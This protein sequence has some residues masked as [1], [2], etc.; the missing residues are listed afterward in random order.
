[1]QPWQFIHQKLST[2]IGVLLLWV[3]ESE[4]SS[5]GRRTFKMAVAAD[6][7]FEGTIGGGI[8]EHKLVEKAKAMLKEDNNIT[9]LV[10]QY[11]D[12]EHAKDQSG[13][14]C[15]GSQLIA[16]VPLNHTHSHIVSEIL[17]SYRDHLDNSIE[18]HPHQLSIIAND[19]EGLQY[20]SEQ[21]WSYKEKIDQRPVIHIIG[22]GHVALA[23][24]EVMHFIGFYVQ[25]YDNR[26]DLHTM[27]LNTSAHEKHV[28]DYANLSNFIQGNSNEYLVIMT[29]GYRDDK[30]VFEQLA[31]KTFFYKGMMG[32]E[33]KL[34]KLR[35]EMLAEGL[36]PQLWNDWHMPIGINIYSKTTQEIA[37][38]IA[39]E[40][41]REKNKIL[42]T[43]RSV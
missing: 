37:I 13:M 14:I 33:T 43:G 24:S 9:S 12:K 32:S 28:V 41:I 8:M 2:S 40:I 27:Q 6:G 5:P 23:L 3:L 4:G 25:V 38:S 17:L 19:S 1:M 34:A 42:P 30:L 35:N 29:F 26:N 20:I 11:H 7:E 10:R 36:D 39:A 22:G 21:E 31:D 15:S 16:F 18:L